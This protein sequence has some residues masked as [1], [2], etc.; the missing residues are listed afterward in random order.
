MEKTLDELEYNEYV[1]SMQEKEDFVKSIV[2]VAFFVE[3]RSVAFFNIY[4]LVIQLFSVVSLTL[5][6]RLRVKFIND[7]K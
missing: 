4:L 1:I 2:A 5:A 7:T 3:H 6:E